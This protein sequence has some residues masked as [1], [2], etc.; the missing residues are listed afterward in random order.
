M[1]LEPYHRQKV[2]LLTQH[3]K[4]HVISPALE[5]LL[6][7]E[8]MLI[9]GYDTDTLGTFSRTVARAGTQ[10]E[11]ARKKARMG[12]NLSGLTLGLGSEGSFGPDP[13]MGMLPWNQELLVFIDDQRGIEVVGIA[14]G[15]AKS[16]HF[17][18]SSWH[19]IEAY[20]QQAGFPQ[21]HLLLRPDNQDDSR[22]HDRLDS[23]DKL[24]SAFNLAL[25]QAHSA[26]VLVE[27]DGRAY[28]NPTR[29]AM[30]AQAADNLAAK[31][32]SHCPAC[33]TPGFWVV[34]HLPGLPCAACRA[35]TRATQAT[36]HACIA[37]DY[38]ET[39]DTPGQG[40]ADPAQC[41]FCNP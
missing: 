18:G 27:V 35:P 32:C 5:P 23:W 40:L 1:S 12:M 14:Q 22:I 10:L 29:M 15:Y 24:E 3:G 33:N 4:E 8:V 31:L 20:A 16:G 39:C 34:E 26:T 30:I 6:G 28:A 41:D 7:C 17:L 11:A 38:R 25:K 37:C 36:R 13:I 2:A 19:E 21:H 9:T